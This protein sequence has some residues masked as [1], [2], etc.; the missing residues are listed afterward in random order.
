MSCYSRV[1]WPD[2]AQRKAVRE[3]AEGSPLA[4]V[5]ATTARD[6]RAAAAPEAQLEERLTR[7]LGGTELAGVDPRFSRLPL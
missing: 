4:L 3:W 2:S 1:A 6:A 5:V 7:L